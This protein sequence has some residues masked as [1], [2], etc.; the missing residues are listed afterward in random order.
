ML[1]EN[2]GN[3]ILPEEDVLKGKK[4]GGKKYYDKR[5]HKKSEKP[6]PVFQRSAVPLI[7]NPDIYKNAKSNNN[8]KGSLT[9][10]HAF[11]D[12][13]DPVPNF[14]RYYSASAKSTEMIYG[15]LVNGANIKDGCEFA[16]TVLARS[17]R[18]YEINKYENM[19]GIPDIWRPVFANPYNWYDLKNLNDFKPLEVDLTNEEEI[20]GRFRVIPI[21]NEDIKGLEWRVGNRGTSQKTIKLDPA[22]NLRSIKL[23]CKIVQLDRPWL[24]SQLFETAGLILGGQD[25]GYYSTG[26]INNNNGILP[27]LPTAIL[28]AI[29]AELDGEWKGR[30]KDIV[31]MIE[32]SSE[33]VSFGPFALSTNPLTDSHA[34]EVNEGVLLQLFGWISDLVPLAPKLRGN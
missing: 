8:P 12:L 4:Y 11:H 22:T 7:I 3:L 29:D 6:L 32:K 34:S 26:N 15:D 30:D 23:K 2:L 21:D 13:I 14:S 17:Q 16:M 25:P 9:S 20:K 27:L 33:A 28:L 5:P 10:L 19:D 18:A 31:K 1:T 24:N